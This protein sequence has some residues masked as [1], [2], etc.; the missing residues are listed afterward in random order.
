M[1]TDDDTITINDVIHG[2]GVTMTS[3]ALAKHL[4]LWRYG[5]GLTL[6]TSQISLSLILTMHIEGHCKY[7]FG[8]T[9]NGI[10]SVTNFLKIQTDLQFLYGNSYNIVT[11]NRLQHDIG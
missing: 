4:G 3:L 7:Q 5:E 6:P 1:H 11:A 9:S 2:V 8:P 10:N